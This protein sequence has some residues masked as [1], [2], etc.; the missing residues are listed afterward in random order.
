MYP[1]LTLIAFLQEPSGLLEA[2][3]KT[4]PDKIN[5]RILKKINMK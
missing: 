2:G 5:K 4:S 1:S 3:I